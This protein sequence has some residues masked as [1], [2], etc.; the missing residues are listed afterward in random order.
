MF[1]PRFIRRNAVPFFGDFVGEPGHDNWEILFLPIL[2]ALRRG[3][4]IGSMTIN[5]I[6]PFAQTAAET[7]N[8]EMDK[9]RDIQREALI[10]GMQE[11]AWRLGIQGLR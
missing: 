11:E 8:A 10:A 4:H 3:L 2:R 6:H 1:G 7:G 5:Y 9:K